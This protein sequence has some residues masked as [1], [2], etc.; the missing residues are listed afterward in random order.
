MWHDRSTLFPLDACNISVEVVREIE[1]EDTGEVIEE[2]LID[3]SGRFFP[4]E[5]DVG[6]GAH[7]EVHSAHLQSKQGRVEGALTDWEVDSLLKLFQE[8]LRTEHDRD[9]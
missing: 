6:L 4:E 1:D 7:I 8:Q 5:N 2:Q 9:F 3:V